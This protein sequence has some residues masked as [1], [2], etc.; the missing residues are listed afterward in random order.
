MKRAPILGLA[1]A[2][3]RKNPD[4]IRVQRPIHR[5]HNVRDILSSGMKPYIMYHASCHIWMQNQP[6][7]LILY[8]AADSKGELGQKEAE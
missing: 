5:H 4:R 7:L 1:S 6:W 3:P 2:R 8:Q